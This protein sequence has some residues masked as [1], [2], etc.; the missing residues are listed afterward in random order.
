MRYQNIFVTSIRVG[1]VI[2]RTT[3]VTTEVTVNP[4][5][6]ALVVID[7]QKDFCYA[8]CALFMGDAI[9]EIIPRISG[10]IEKAAQKRCI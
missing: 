6:S 9:E 2:E 5:E 1:I 4:E 8:D 7:M 10:L 3:E